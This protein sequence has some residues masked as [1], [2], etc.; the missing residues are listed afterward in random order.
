MNPNKQARHYEQAGNDINPLMPVPPQS[1]PHGRHHDPTSTTSTNVKMAI[2]LDGK[3]SRSG[4]L[5][6]CVTRNTT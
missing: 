5:T 1:S 3:L 4:R 2:R 6:V